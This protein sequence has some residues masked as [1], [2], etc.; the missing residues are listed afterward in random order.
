MIPSIKRVIYILI[1]GLDF[2]KLR[3][4]HISGPKGLASD[5]EEKKN[6]HGK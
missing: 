4:A 1:N 6:G 2:D 3:N 5:D